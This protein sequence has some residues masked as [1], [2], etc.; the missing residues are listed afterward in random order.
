M[1]AGEYLNT[2]LS[3]FKDMI[4]VFFIVTSAFMLRDINALLGMPEYIIGAVKD[5]VSP[6]LLPAAAFIIVSLLG[7][8]AGNFWG[9]CAISFPVIIPIAQALNCN[10]LLTA[11][12]IISATTA[13]SN[14]CFYGAEATLACSAAQIENIRYAQTAIPLIVIPFILSI[15]CYAAAGFLLG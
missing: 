8:A 4:N 14:A 13:S 9:I 12:A 7:F 3:G 10:L 6:E 5:G 1:T 15:I 2:I 11:G